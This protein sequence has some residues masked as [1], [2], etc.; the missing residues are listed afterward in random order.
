MK[1][2][3]KD[4]EKKIQ[5]PEV[6]DIPGQEHIRPPEMREMQDTTISSDD[7]E[8]A[9][10]VES[11]N[12]GTPNGE[13]GMDNSS[14][15]SDEEAHLLDKTDRANTDESR[16][17]ESLKLENSDGA[18][19]LNEESDL[20]DMGADLDVPGAELDDENEDIGSEDE[21]NNAYSRPD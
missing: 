2:N 8:G 11:L 3:H 17:I 18:D 4:R 1:T 16:D 21:E 5:V 12:G 7:E 15:V 19:P 20:S 10:L 9:G 14:N 13:L 6:K